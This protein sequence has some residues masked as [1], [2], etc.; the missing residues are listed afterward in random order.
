VR[1]RLSLGQRENLENDE[2]GRLREA[3]PQPCHDYQPQPMSDTGWNRRRR[4]HVESRAGLAR[5]GLGHR[6]DSEC[7]AQPHVFWLHDGWLRLS[8]FVVKSFGTLSHCAGNP[9]HRRFITQRPE[10]THRSTG[11][12]NDGTQSESNTHCHGC[13]QHIVIRFEA[14]PAKGAGR[15]RGLH[16]GTEQRGRRASP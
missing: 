11:K 12:S 6:P 14:A 3:Q 13:S 1:A 8:G 7:T 2:A 5:T 16:S 4:F 15:L 10:H 9:H